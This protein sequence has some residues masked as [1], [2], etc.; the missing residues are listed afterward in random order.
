M[1]RCIPSKLAALA[2]VAGFAGAAASEDGFPGVIGDDDRRIV[3]SWEAPWSAIGRVNVAGYRRRGA[4]TGTLIAP[5]LVATA[6]HCLFDRGSGRPVPVGNIHFVAGQRR[7]RF[8]AHAKAKCV[9]LMQGHRFRKQAS[10]EAFRSDV[11]VIVL[12]QSL[13]IAPVSLAT[14][15]EPAAGTPLVHPGYGRDRPYLLSVDSTCRVQ[16]EA[17]GVLLTDCDTNFGGSGGPVLV[18]E[19]GVLRL[20]AVM[21]GFSQGGYSAAVD[22]SKWPEL[23]GA[24]G[25]R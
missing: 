5:D 14:I 18:R 7:D 9:R 16:E 12:K 4:C 22:T 24:S 13:T 20:L 15:P 19:N 17:D 1:V 6:A 8:L 25:C 11:A 10:I 21:V 3:D 23:R 2:L